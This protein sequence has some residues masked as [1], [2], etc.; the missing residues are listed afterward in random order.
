MYSMSLKSLTSY[1]HAPP[2]QLYSHNQCEM[3]FER[4]VEIIQ[5]VLK[6][7]NYQLKK[8]YKMY[9]IIQFSSC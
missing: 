1:L 6:N 5:I 2:P 3:C 9:T 8:T 7:L 4:K